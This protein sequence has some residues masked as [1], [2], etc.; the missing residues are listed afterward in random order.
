[1]EGRG[2]RGEGRGERGNRRGIEQEG[3]EE[4]ENEGSS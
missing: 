2:E 4:E 1:M 3:G